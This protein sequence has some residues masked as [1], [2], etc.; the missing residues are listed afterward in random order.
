MHDFTCIA[1]RA[2]GVQSSR[3]DL[4]ARRRTTSAILGG[5]LLALQCFRVDII[6]SKSRHLN[7]LHNIQILEQD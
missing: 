4:P 7:D 3:I 2:S 6:C 1:V 5:V